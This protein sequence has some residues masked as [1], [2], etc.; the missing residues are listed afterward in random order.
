M[1]I[2]ERCMRVFEMSAFPVLMTYYYIDLC[3]KNGLYTFEGSDRSVK[4]GYTESG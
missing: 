4:S 2:V 1:R 3:L